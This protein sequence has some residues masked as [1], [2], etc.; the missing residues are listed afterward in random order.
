MEYARLRKF[1][2]CLL[3]FIT[4]SSIKKDVPNSSVW[5]HVVPGVRTYQSLACIF[6]KWGVYSTR[7]VLKPP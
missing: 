6:F 7:W 3:K 1:L 5:G 4:I 2:R